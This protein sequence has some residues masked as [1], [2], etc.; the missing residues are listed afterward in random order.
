M[1]ETIINN[2]D[3]QKPNAFVFKV[4]INDEYKLCICPRV[5]GAWS[6][7][8]TVYID[9]PVKELYDSLEEKLL[10]VIFVN[11]EKDEN[12]GFWLKPCENSHFIKSATLIALDLY[13]QQQ[14]FPIIEQGYRNI[15]EQSSERQGGQTQTSE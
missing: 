5:D 10:H 11:Y 3:K 14:F 4:L 13:S 1:S 7:A 12:G 8:D 2:T 9:N 6:E 15:Y